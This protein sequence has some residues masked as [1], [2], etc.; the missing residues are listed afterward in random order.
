MFCFPRLKPFKVLT[1]FI[2]RS[3]GPQTSCVMAR[4]LRVHAFHRAVA[5][6]CLCHGGA[7][8][9]TVHTPDP[10]LSWRS[11]TSFT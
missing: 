6:Q 8:F 7:S 1:S 11:V 10:V 9:V 2:G 4:D 3:S 5:L